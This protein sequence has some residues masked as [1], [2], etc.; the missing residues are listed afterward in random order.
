MNRRARH[1][2]MMAPLCILMVLFAAAPEASA[3]DDNMDVDVDEYLQ[4]ETI[5]FPGQSV[6]AQA[7]SN[8]VVE[9]FPKIGVW[10]ASISGTM[11]AGT[12]PQQL[13]LFTDLGLESSTDGTIVYG[14]ISLGFLAIRYSSFF[15]QFDGQNTLMRDINFGGIDFTITD[16]ITS[17]LEIN[18]YTLTL[19]IRLI[20]VAGF[21]FYVEAGVSYYQLAGTVTS[22]TFGTGTETADVPVPVIGVLVQQSFKPFFVEFEVMGLELEYDTTSGAVLDIQA[23]IGIRFLHFIAARAGYRYID[24]DGKHDDFDVG[25]QLDGFFFSVGIVF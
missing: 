23:S 22:T 5:L 3:L 4:L 12:P 17:S 11:S 24:F 15:A 6:D 13:D 8:P 19:A 9:I 1:L 21:K 14:Q 20:N 10:D 16:N 25:V 18:N 2:G 7:I